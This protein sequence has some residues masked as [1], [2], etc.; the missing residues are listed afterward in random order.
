MLSEDS[1]Q[2]VSLLVWRKG[3]WDDEVAAWRKLVA[4]NPLPDVGKRGRVSHGHVVSEEVNVLRSHV[5]IG[6]L[7]NT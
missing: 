7:G 2:E 5:S 3:A 4:T 1:Q 6:N